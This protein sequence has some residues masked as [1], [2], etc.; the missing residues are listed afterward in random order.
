VVLLTFCSAALLSISAIALDRFLSVSQPL[1]YNHFVTM[2][3]VQKYVV[4][5]WLL[6]VLLGGAPFFLQKDF[7]FEVLVVTGSVL[8][9]IPVLVSVVT[10]YGYIYVI[11]R[12]HARAIYSVEIS[13]NHSGL[14]EVSDMSHT[15]VHHG[16]HHR[17]GLMLALLIGALLLWIPAQVCAA[18]DAFGK[19]GILQV[20]EWRLLAVSP[21]VFTSVV[22]PWLYAYRSSEVSK[23]VYDLAP[24]ILNYFILIQA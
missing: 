16:G 20:H 1:R 4:G 11:A 24:L 17:Y 10:S 23:Y 19:A 13:L 5:S 21:I 8:I 6:S 9:Y 12:S 15:T 14:I 18:V 2:S 3:H 22:N 7:D